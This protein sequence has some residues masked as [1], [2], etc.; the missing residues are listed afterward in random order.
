MTN[1]NKAAQDGRQAGEGNLVWAIR[2]R[3]LG[4]LV[5]FKED[6]VRSSGH[7]GGKTE[8]KEGELFHFG[9]GLAVCQQA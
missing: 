1:G 8:G 4:I 5:R 7:G 3:A 2:R 6:P 9:S